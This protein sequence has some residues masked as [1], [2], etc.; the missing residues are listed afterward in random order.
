MNIDIDK[1]TLII[2]MIVVFI[3]FMLSS[4]CLCNEK[5]EDVITDNTQTTTDNTQTT[6]DNTTDNTQTTTDNTQVVTTPEYSSY[7]FRKISS[8]QKFIGF[9]YVLVDANTNSDVL[10]N[11]DNIIVTNDIQGSDV[12]GRTKMSIPIMLKYNN[13][14][15]DGFLNLQSKSKITP[16]SVVNAYF[17]FFQ[18]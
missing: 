14:Y 16:T 18:K 5:F 1:N 12:L 10:Y 8:G 3:I 11:D 2:I 6:T 17:S 15:R 7:T 4:S 13:K 9:D